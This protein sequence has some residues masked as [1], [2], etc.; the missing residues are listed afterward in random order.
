[1]Q[2]Q[3]TLSNK[4]VLY[5]SLLRLCFSEA[6][7]KTVTIQSG[8]LLSLLTYWRH[9]CH[10]S[11]ITLSVWPWASPLPLGASC[12]FSERREQIG[13]SPKPL[14]VL[15]HWHFHFLKIHLFVDSFTAVPK[16]G[17]WF[18]SLH[19]IGRLP[20]TVNIFPPAERTPEETGAP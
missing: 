12:P 18:G 16:E 9:P 19:W 15:S 11:S 6:W 4:Y 10:G 1:M 14:L 17:R 7:P 2:V 8:P 13:W 5:K 20:E 3:I